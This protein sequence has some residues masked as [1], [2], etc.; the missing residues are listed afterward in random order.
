VREECVALA[1]QTVSPVQTATLRAA[2][3][4]LT[5]SGPRSSP[6]TRADDAIAAIGPTFMNNA[7]YSTHQI[8]KPARD[9]F[10]ER[11]FGKNNF[12]FRYYLMF[13]SLCA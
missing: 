9:F 7:G 3:D 8:Y 6:E 1:Q 4:R 10:P 2:S 13:G 5:S 12:D 11:V